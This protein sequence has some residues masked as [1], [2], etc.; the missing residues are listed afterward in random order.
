M[1]RRPPRYTRTDTLLPSTTLFRSFASSGRP[2]WRFLP[3]LGPPL[4][5][6]FL[7]R[8]CS[9]NKAALQNGTRSSVGQPSDRRHWQEQPTLSNVERDEPGLAI[10]G[11]CRAVARI[12][13]DCIDCQRLVPQQYPTERVQ[14]PARAHPL[15]TLSHF[16]PQPADH[17]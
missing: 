16:Q 9:P 12:D 11:G 7:F 5:V 3:K 4:A 1:Q 6:A 8:T 10:E 14:H 15:A 17:P 13:D 2:T